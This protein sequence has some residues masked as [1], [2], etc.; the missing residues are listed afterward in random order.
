[1]H[2]F[3]FTVLSQAPDVPPSLFERLLSPAAIGT[4]ISV[5][6]GL[7]AGIAWLSVRRKKL[8]ALGSYYAF[9]IVEDIGA[10]LD[11]EDG[12]DKTARYLKELDAYMVANG[13]RPLKPGEVAVA[14]MQ[15]S[16]LHG[17]EVAKAKVAEAAATAAAAF[18]RP[19][20]AATPSIRGPSPAP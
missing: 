12:F 15:A 5:V 4:A 7:V 14:K 8:L 18:G 9:H 11:G 1:M 19:D 3:L 2:Q 20:P 17:V 10:E 16:A 13:W 6:G